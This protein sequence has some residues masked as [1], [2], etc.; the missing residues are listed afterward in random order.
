MAIEQAVRQHKRCKSQARKDIQK[1]GYELYKLKLFYEY[2]C[3]ES[4]ITEEVVDLL[5][6]AEKII[7]QV[8]RKQ[9]LCR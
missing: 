8:R 3:A 1:I 4:G 6:E 5:S 7:D 9:A 2:G